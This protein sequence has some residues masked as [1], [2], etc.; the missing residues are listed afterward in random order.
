MPEQ[1]NDNQ[2]EEESD[3]TMRCSYMDIRDILIELF[4]AHPLF[5]RNGLETTITSKENLCKIA[6]EDR[7]HW[8]QRYDLTLETKI[9]ETTITNG[10]TI[11]KTEDLI[12]IVKQEKDYFFKGFEL[13]IGE[14]MAAIHIKEQLLE[15]VNAMNE[16]RVNEQRML[17]AARAK[18]AALFEA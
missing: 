10:G 11:T 15:I 16:A 17:H 9:K 6:M 5:R 12:L 14:N 13:T 3:V 18:I 1:D 8:K 2:L 7:F 4:L